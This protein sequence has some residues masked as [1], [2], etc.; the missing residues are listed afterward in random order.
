M[1]TLGKSLHRI[2]VTSGHTTVMDW[3]KHVGIPYETIRGWMRG[4][5]EPAW[6]RTLRTIKRR[7]R[8]SW[9]EILDGRE[10][11]ARKVSVTNPDSDHAIGHSECSEC[12]AVV[13]SVDKY[14]RAC[15]RRFLEDE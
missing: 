2:Y 1:T 14:C 15:G 8:M 12:G 5:T 7:T 4:E 6:L 3:C 13:Y 11:T 10:R 9:D